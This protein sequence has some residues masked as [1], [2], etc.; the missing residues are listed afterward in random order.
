MNSTPVITSTTEDTICDPG[1]ATLSVTGDIPG[2][3]SAPSFNWY[4]T[5]TSSTVLGNLD[6]F[7]PNITTTTTFWVEA[8]ANGCT[9]E[10]E[11]VTATV[12]PQPSAGTPTDRSA[13]SVADNGPTTVD[14]D[15]TL[16]G[17]DPGVWSVTQDPSGGITIA[18]GTNVVDFEGL[19]DGNYIF[20]YTTT[21][22]QPP[23]SNESSQV[24]IFVNDCDVDSDGDGLFDGEEAVL[25]TNP[26]DR[27]SDGDGI[28][29]GVEVGNV[30]NPLDEDGD[31]IID[32]LDSN[33]L[34]SDSDGVNDQQ[35]PANNDAC[36]PDNS[37]ALCDTDGDGLVDADELDI[38][39]DPNDPD[40]DDDEINDGEEVTN[41]TDP[42]DPCDPNTASPACNLEA[43]IQ[44][45]KTF[46]PS[47]VN[48]GETVGFT[49][50]ANNV[51]DVDISDIL[52]VDL[53]ENGFRFISESTSEG[54]YD[55]NTGE[56]RIALLEA[57]RSATLR[58]TA[59]VLSVGPYTNTAQLIA[60]TPV[61][62]NTSNDVATVT[63]PLEFEEGVDLVIEK[64]AL[65]S[66][67]LTGDQI[68]FTIRVTNESREDQISQIR[69][70]DVLG[71]EF[72]YISDTS[73]SGD[74]DPVT[75]EWLI[76]VLAL[77][78]EATLQITVRVPFEG[79]YTNE[80]R[81]ISS[82][83]VDDPSNNTASVVVLVSLP[84]VADPGF[85]FNQFSPNRDG[86]N[87]FLK[88]RDIGTFSNTSINIFNRYG[89]LVFEARNMTDDRVWDGTRNGKAVP[90][91]T[92]FYILDLG[93][94]SAERK[95]WIQVIR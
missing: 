7:T 1:Q 53:L 72:E 15:D 12:V 59:E 43:D 87:D 92:Y 50:T 54:N 42:L 22:A 46:N 61:D 35:D 17:A 5:Q 16:T 9:S 14:L 51:S 68:V 11:A 65:S 78:Q 41:G 58:I 10:R 21:G 57:R 13:C 56:W 69:V 79:T 49:I 36:I 55:S 8:T 40:T 23:C 64:T 83:P 2:S 95:G 73:D 63:L 27:D 70:R 4:A 84:T 34:D 62:T 52:I 76:P 47:T 20:T 19:P 91:G 29:D 44:I 60:S 67:P 33:I 24:T 94:G 80:A 31:G 74:Y 82:S 45:L 25:G 28:E 30:S 90:A 89:E 26:L 38:G 66:R 18:P 71:N 39:T 3:G 93:D 86:T 32:A 81:I 85:I 48:I 75:G 37:N 77:N 6:T 88:I